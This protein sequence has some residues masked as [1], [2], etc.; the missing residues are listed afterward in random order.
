MH[1]CCQQYLRMEIAKNE[2][3]R[4]HRELIG[5]HRRENMERSTAGKKKRNPESQTTARA[6]RPLEVGVDELHNEPITSHL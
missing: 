3:R 1:E 5:E 2:I 6:Y 4:M